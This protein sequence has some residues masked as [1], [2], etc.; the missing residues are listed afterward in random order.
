MPESYTP[1]SF[2]EALYSHKHTLLQPRRKLER[3]PATQRAESLLAVFADQARVETAYRDQQTAGT[4]L[5]SLVPEPHQSLEEILRSAA[6]YWNLSVEQ[7][8]FYLR[9]VFGG[10]AVSDAERFHFPTA[11][12]HGHSAR[13]CGQGNAAFQVA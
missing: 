6:A 13:A 12:P 7:L 10:A 8:P 5:L 2:R 1:E 4:L 11:G 3:L 9:E